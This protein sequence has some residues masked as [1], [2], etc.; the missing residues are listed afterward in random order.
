[1]FIPGQIKAT[2]KVLITSQD[3]LLDLLLEAF[4]I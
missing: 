2:R 4:I 1:M 3:K